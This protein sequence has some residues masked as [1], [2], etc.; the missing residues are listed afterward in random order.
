MIDGQEKKPME[1]S[2][3]PIDDPTDDPTI[4]VT[5]QDL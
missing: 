2:G 5:N 3:R 1:S 4:R